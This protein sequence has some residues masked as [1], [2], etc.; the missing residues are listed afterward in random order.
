MTNH[1][2]SQIDPSKV[3][4]R[5]PPSFRPLLRKCKVRAMDYMDQVAYLGRCMRG[6]DI[7]FCRDTVVPLSILGQGDGRWTIASSHIPRNPIV[8]SFGI[9]LDISF[10]LDMIDQ[11][12]AQIYAFDPTPIA[13]QWLAT[14]SLPSSFHY[15]DCGL[16]G[17]DGELLFS[18]PLNHGVSFTSLQNGVPSQAMGSFPVKRLS[19]LRHQ[20]KHT[21]VDLIKIDIEGAEY[22]II[23]DL[24]E[25]ADSF[26][27]LLIEF[28][29]RM[30]PQP[31]SIKKT[32]L[33]VK[34]LRGAG[35]KLFAVSPRGLELSF[36]R[37]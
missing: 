34:K 20:L 14:N 28:H 9:G 35:F 23:D 27:Q 29:H 8:Y 17:Y 13:K 10:D 18:L 30:L 33:A 3:L 24:V 26:Q 11:F 1:L 7:F 22:S 25:S 5:L 32:A 6:S 12:G 4:R 2:Y 15:V 16:A 19:S 31:Q 37:L 21:H 36:I